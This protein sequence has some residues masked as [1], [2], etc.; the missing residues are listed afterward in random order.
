MLQFDFPWLFALLPLPLLIWWLV[1]PYRE[2]TPALR[3]PFLEQIAAATGAT[4][5]SGAV[6]PR[7]NLGQQLLAPLCW[8]SIVAALAA[9]QWVGKPIEKT[10]SAR[11]LLLAI[12]LSQSM[13]TRDF[14][15][16]ING[17]T[18]DRLNA[19][20]AVVDDFIERRRDDRI[21]LIVFGSGA[22]PQ[23]PLTLDHDSVRALLDET[24][25]GMAGPQTA[26]GDAI[27]IAIK[28]LDDTASKTGADV[29]AP[30]T[31]RVLILLTD[32]NDTASRLPPAQ[33]A[34]VAQQ[35]RLIIHT[36]AIGD[37]QASGENRVDL[38]A[39][40]KIAD[41]TGGRSFR[42]EDRQQL[43]D[44]YTTLDRITPRKVTRATYRPKQ[45]LYWIP[46]G[47]GAL[48]LTLYHGAMLLAHA[49]RL[50][51]TRATLAAD[52]RESA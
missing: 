26:I 33:A 44:I 13:E 10:Q 16:P 15:D 9:P 25:I 32:G 3:M 51:S 23:T 28:L 36:I 52:A 43:A 29:A 49:T 19:V 47:A 45:A 7:S 8:L 34:K 35:H 41:A 6:V 21:G 5:G 39:L 22:F 24:R 50:R 42:G 37:P 12:D 17:N 46:L 1:P 4:P 40:R 2:R 30:S 14:I 18:T 38:E 11:D 27:G 48:L 20:K 31:E